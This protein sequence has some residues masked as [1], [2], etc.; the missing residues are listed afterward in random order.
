MKSSIFF[1]IGSLL[2]LFIVVSAD[3]NDDECLI[4]DAMVGAAVAVCQEFD[5]CRTLMFYLCILSISVSLFAFIFGGPRVRR[6]MLRDIPSK[7]SLAATTG[8]Y[9][10]TRMFM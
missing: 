6:K 8:G 10:L 2:L 9:S 3:D 7:R 1:I 5:T 4:C